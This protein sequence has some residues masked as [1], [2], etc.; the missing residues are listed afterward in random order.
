[1]PALP[2]MFPVTPSSSL[3]SPASLF[4]PIASPAPALPCPAPPAPP[5]HTHRP[6]RSFSRAQSNRSLHYRATH[7]TQL[8]RPHTRTRQPSLLRRDYRITRSGV[9][10]PIHLSTPYNL[11][12]HRRLLIWVGKPSPCVAA[13]VARCNFPGSSEERQRALTRRGDMRSSERI[14]NS[15]KRK[16]PAPYSDNMSVVVVA[17]AT[18]SGR[19]ARLTACRVSAAPCSASSSVMGAPAAQST[20]LRRFAGVALAAFAFT[21]EMTHVSLSLTRPACFRSGHAPSRQVRPRAMR[22]SAA[23]SD[24]LLLRVCRGEGACPLSRV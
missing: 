23:A 14:R 5:A 12:C 4:R 13:Q 9:H 19:A 11:H 18:L 17:V 24:P 2:L 6:A 20:R 15:S 3:T 7:T 22:I 10:P 16:R 1:L 8:W 21:G